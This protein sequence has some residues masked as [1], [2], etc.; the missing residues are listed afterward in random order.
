MPDLLS[1]LTKINNLVE[2]ITS[3]FTTLFSVYLSEIPEDVEVKKL[4]ENGNVVTVTIPNRAKLIEELKLSTGGE[5]TAVT[6]DTIDM[7]IPYQSISVNGNTYNVSVPGDNKC[8]TVILKVTGTLDEFNWGTAGVVW[9]GNPPDTIVSEGSKFLI[10]F[11]A[12]DSVAFGE[13]IEP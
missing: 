10:R 7:T 8:R 4:D 1:A 9:I 3:F 6:G 13:V 2:V 12:F 5:F 11:T